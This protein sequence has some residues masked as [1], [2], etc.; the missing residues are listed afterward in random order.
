[1]W[2]LQTLGEKEKSATMPLIELVMPTVQLKKT[3]IVK[4]K[5][6]SV[7]KTDNEVFTEAIQKFKGKRVPQIPKEILEAWGTRPVFLDF[8]LLYEAQ[9][10]TKLKVDSANKI[11]AE[12][13][14][15]GLTIIPVL[16][17]ND[18]AEFKEAIVGLSKQY[19]DGFCLRV[20]TSD[21]EAPEELNRKIDVFLKDFDLHRN[22]IDLL[23]DVKRIKEDGGE[24][25]RFIKAS[26]RIK[27][28][29]E[30][31]NF[32]FASGAFP[33]SLMDC[34]VDKETL[35]PRLDWLNWLKYSKG[36][37]LI[38]HPLFADYAIRNPIFDSATQ[39][40]NST[41]SI[42]YTLENDWLIMKGRLRKYE[43]YLANAR[44]LVENTGYFYGKNFCWGD[45]SIAQ[46]AQYFHQYITDRNKKLI[47]EG[48]GA[49]RNTDWIAWGISHHLTLV[50]RQISNLS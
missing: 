18:D 23:V 21:L 10:T 20:T 16:N 27:A 38:R 35:L 50:I 36:K 9:L 31:R 32:I 11:I 29:S 4:G 45:Q 6:E 2:A 46:K 34:K 42:K 5:R 7:K 41:P 30:W 17:L 12:G 47:E 14:G 15:M 40:Y 1:M 24:Y 39:Y 43:D 8:T 26:Q 3:V 44:L 48:K 13:V 37:E 22:E 33:S 28:L 25:L 49:G 19:S